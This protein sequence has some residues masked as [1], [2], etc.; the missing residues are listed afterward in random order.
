MELKCAV[1]R[2]KDDSK[3][4]SGRYSPQGNYL[5]VEIFSFIFPH[6]K[7]SIGNHLLKWAARTA[8]KIMLLEAE[9]SGDG[10]FF[11]IVIPEFF[12]DFLGL[13]ID[14]FLK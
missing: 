4:I 13:L 7:I 1:S 5:L 10:L 6:N 12:C 14:F 3:K 11:V 2:R 8:E 9:L